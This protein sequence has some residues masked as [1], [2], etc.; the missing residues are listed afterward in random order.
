MLVPEVLLSGHDKNIREWRR[1]QALDITLERRPD[2]LDKE[3]LTKEDVLY[4][5]E[6]GWCADGKEK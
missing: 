5:K 3:K 4:L 2:L 6:K 1:R